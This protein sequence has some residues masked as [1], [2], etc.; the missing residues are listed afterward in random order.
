VRL[1]LIIALNPYAATSSLVGN[2]HEKILFFSAHAAWVNHDTVGPGHN[3]VTVTQ[4]HDNSSANAS[5]KD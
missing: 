3:E 2:F 5:E 1:P 4:D